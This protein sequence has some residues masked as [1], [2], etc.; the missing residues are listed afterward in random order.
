MFHYI[1][2]RLLQSVIVL[3]GVLIIVFFTLRLSG[4]PIDVLLPPGASEEMVEI[5]TEQLGLDKPLVAQFGIYLMNIFQGD[6][7]ISYYYKESVTSIIFERLPATIQLTLFSFLFTLI[8]GIPAGVYSALKSGKASDYI[9]R[10][11]ALIGQCM[12]AFW[13][14]LLLIII[15]AV[16]LKLF[17]TQGTGSFSNLVL[18]SITLGLYSAATTVR[19]LRSSMLEVLSKDYIQVAASKGLSKRRIVWKHAFKNAVTAILTVL[20]IQVAGLLAGSMIV[21][22]VFSWPGIGRLVVQSINNRDFAVVQAVV[23]LIASIY[24]IINLLV[25]VLYSMINPRVRLM[26]GSSK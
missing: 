18:P 11:F 24:V 23:I 21:E 20:G 9:V 7:G 25:D 22:T 17:P 16:Q 12:P 1:L 2:K 15:F 3:L 6:F 4:N 19:L 10:I 5:Y 14:G 13:V 26:K 8:I